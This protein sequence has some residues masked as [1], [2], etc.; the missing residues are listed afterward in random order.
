MNEKI[1]AHFAE[2]A[3]YCDMFGSP[4]TSQL[5]RAMSEDYQSGGP[6]A[7]QLEEWNTSPRADALALRLAG[8]FH[9][10]VLVG[11]EAALAA[12]YPSSLANWSI[13]DVWPLARALL[14]REPN[15]AAAFIRSAP[16]TNETRRSIALL[17]AFLRFADSWKGEVDML[18]IGASA[19]LNMNWDLYTYQ[20]KSWAWGAQGP[21]QIDTDWNG[22]PP[23]IAD[24]AVRHRAA[25]D[26]NPLDISDEHERL[27]L[28][29]YVWPDQPERLARFDGAVALARETGVHVERADAA[30]W[31]AQKL[32][33]RA[34]D[35]AT[36][37]YHSVFLQYPPREA[38]EAI[39]DA[40]LSAGAR[41]TERAPLA[42]VRL[43]PE[44][45]TDDARDSPRMVIDVT[46]WP[47]AKR[48]IVGYTDGH[49]RAVYAV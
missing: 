26:L 22:P 6:I 7:A 4:F 23:P 12:H 28:R 49:V 42:W 44:A 9:H 47:G 41:A 43:E 24:I 35:A 3:M 33:A 39:V 36:I 2:Q 48:R 32:S 40:I 5:I 19:G 31:L 38:R 46:T 25:C 37:V 10:A 29:S 15:A 30:H 20:T 21:V 34:D 16:Q 45:L 17:A 11:R 1:L 14:E 27:Q 18:E 13:E 8:Y